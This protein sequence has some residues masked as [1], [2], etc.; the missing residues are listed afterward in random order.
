[1][2]AY[3]AARDD[4]W[5]MLDQLAGFIDQLAKLTSAEGPAA[6]RA[7]VPPAE[8]F[9]SSLIPTR[10]A[11]LSILTGSIDYG[12]RED[13]AILPMR[14]VELDRLAQAVEGWRG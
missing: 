3:N 4:G 5:E 9:P 7:Q 10:T 13:F 11:L 12:W 8:N 1:M 6:A 2:A 14:A